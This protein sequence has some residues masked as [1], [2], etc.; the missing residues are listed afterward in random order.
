MLGEAIEAAIKEINEIR[1][2]IENYKTDL[3][4]NETLV[5]YSLIDPFLRLLGWDTANPS[6]VVPEY[7]TGSGRADYALIDSE[8]NLIA[9]VGAKKLGTPEDLN[10]HITYCN[11]SNV[12]YFI[13][14]DG[15]VWE[16][17]DVFKRAK[18][19]E[20]MIARWVI[21]DENPGEIIKKALSISNFSEFGSYA[22]KPTYSEN[23]ESE[24]NTPK[25]ETF[26]EAQKREKRA[27]P[28]RPTAL[29][30]GGVSVHVS[31]VREVLIQT[32]EWLIKNHKLKVEDAP[33]ESGPIRYIVNVKPR[34][35]SGSNFFDSY[36]LSNGL[37]LEVHGSHEAVEINAR[38][39][40]KHFGYEEKT[41][42]VSW[43]KE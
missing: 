15:N 28:T 39:L 1:Q 11:S 19:P 37:F 38:T 4:K 30:I 3:S 35:K 22:E 43:G 26:L 21:T 36:K 8:S 17:Y 31:K 18:T 7:S 40:M 41:L 5:R 13:A 9:F 27:A 2:K 25:R 16:I 33:I 10:Q 32:A 6:Q 23:N 24:P 34:H 29:V 20:K 14:T 12:S 42:E